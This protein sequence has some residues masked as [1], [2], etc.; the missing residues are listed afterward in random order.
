M[1]IAQVR[2]KYKGNLYYRIPSNYGKLS[3]FCE[4]VNI[5]MLYK[6]KNI[7]SLVELTLMFVSEYFKRERNQPVHPSG[8]YFE[9]NVNKQ[10]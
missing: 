3:S 5:N 7:N 6:S 4:S 8:F 10:N 2:M 1:Q 9:T